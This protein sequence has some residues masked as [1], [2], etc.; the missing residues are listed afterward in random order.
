[1]SV[2]T[3]SPSLLNISPP[4]NQ[5]FAHDYNPC[6]SGESIDGNFQKNVYRHN[7]YLIPT[8]QNIL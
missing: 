2:R 6:K 7:V 5:N 1:M 8:S 3:M 4:K